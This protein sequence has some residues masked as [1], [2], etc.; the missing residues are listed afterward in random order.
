MKIK[1]EKGF[2]LIEI[3]LVVVI[4]GIM[5]AVIVPRAWRANIDTKIGLVRQNASELGNYGMTWAET[6]LMGQDEV[7]SDAILGDYLAY[8]CGQPNAATAAAGQLW[9]ADDATGAGWM[10][11]GSQVT[12]RTVDGVTN[13]AP[14]GTAQKFVPVDKIPRNPF[15]GQ[16]VF[17]QMNDPLTAQA[18]GVAIPGAIATAFI[19]ETGTTMGDL[20]YYYAFVFQGTESTG[21]GFVQANLFGDQDATDL[22]GLRN[23]I[24]FART[25]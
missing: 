7:G 24:F 12:G 1:R 22:I 10:I 4:I 5:L 19:Q 14:K 25:K 11:T 8:L 13:Q 18:G 17:S 9:V 16:S 15:N 20:F 21:T 6:E 23:G 2:T 3:L